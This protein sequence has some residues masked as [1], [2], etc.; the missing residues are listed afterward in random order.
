[1]RN[2]EG[3]PAARRAR[4]GPLRG[5]RR[6]PPGPL[7]GETGARAREHGRRARARARPPERARRSR[8]R[9][10][11]RRPGGLLSA[12]L[13]LLNVLVGQA[14]EGRLLV[15]NGGVYDHL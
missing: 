10:G 1:V 14:A 6:P 12:R 8:G 2:M 3:R 11:R 9:A 5:P 4:A 15:Q 7:A 13:L